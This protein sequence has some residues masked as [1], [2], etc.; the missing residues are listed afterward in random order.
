MLP[1]NP[2]VYERNF[3]LNLPSYDKLV[4]PVNGAYFLIVTVVIFGG[5]WACCIFRKRRRHDGIPYQELEMGLPESMAATEVETAEGWDQGWD[6]DWDEN[7]AVK[8]PVGRHVS[9]IS[10]NG[11]TARSSNRDG[12]EN[13]WDD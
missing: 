3:F 7:K 11:L 5:S 2:L 6:D 8:S 10:A 12:W 4:T 13:D 9:N 1:L